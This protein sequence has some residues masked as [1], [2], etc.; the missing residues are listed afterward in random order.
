MN[1]NKSLS[2][3]YFVTEGRLKKYEDKI[4]KFFFRTELSCFSKEKLY[5]SSYDNNRWC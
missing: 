5:I 3:T 1:E 4:W 2:K